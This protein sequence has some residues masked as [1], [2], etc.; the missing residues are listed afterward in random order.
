MIRSVL[1][2]KKLLRN[3]KLEKGHSRKKRSNK[4]TLIIIGI[5]L[6]IAA[7][8]LIMVL[9]RQKPVEPETTPSV[10]EETTTVKETEETATVK[11]TEETTE[12]P[13]EETT[14]ET[15]AEPDWFYYSDKERNEHYF[16]P[17]ENAASREFEWNI[18]RVDEFGNPVFIQT[19]DS[20]PEYEMIRGVDVSAEQGKIDWYKVRDARCDFVIIRADEMFAEHYDGAYKLGLKIGVYY[21]S[22]ASSPEEA[23]ADAEEFLSVIGERKIDLYAA[24][25]PEDMYLEGPFGSELSEAEREMCFRNADVELNTD[26][27][28]AFCEIIEAA[29]FKP[30]IYSSLRYEAEMYDMSRLSGRYDFWYTD[31]GGTPETPYPF[32]TWQYCLTGGIKGITGPVNLD[33]Y[34]QRPYEETEAEQGIYGY[35][36]FYQEAYENTTWVNYRSVNEAWNGEW[37][38][39]K[40][41]GQEFMIFGCGICCLSNAV[42]TLTDTVVMPDEMYYSTKEQTSYYPESGRGAVSWDIMK[43]MAG[44]YGLDMKPCNKPKDYE[45]FVNDVASADNTVVLVNG[46]NDRRLWWYTDG[47]YVS[48]WEYDP[49]TD[50]VFV[51]DPSTQ[52]NRLRVKLTD[53]YH[54]LKTGSNYQYAVISR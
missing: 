36:Q 12:K 10:T 1:R 16:L 34:L 27:A 54:A 29:G 46:D 48:I 9:R 42:S 53:I 15:T 14:E 44:Y 26:I 21:C 18:P 32:S 31:F 24:Y 7:V 3:G 45:K 25:V 30:A 20:Y 43:H 33:V 41:G 52:Y 49:E 22:D 35:T 8:I 6:L 47:H 17:D 19:D 28:E 11:E 39:I 38:R 5:I 50:T 13:T 37:A 23:L 4:N 40:A 51:T 2:I